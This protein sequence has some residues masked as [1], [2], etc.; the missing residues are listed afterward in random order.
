MRTAALRIVLPSEVDAVDA[1][2]GDGICAS[3]DVVHSDSSVQE[4][5][6]VI[7]FESRGEEAGCSCEPLP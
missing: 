5:R 2:P 3:P 4:H 6:L 7:H 1:S